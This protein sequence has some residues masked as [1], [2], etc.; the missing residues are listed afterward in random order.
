MFWAQGRL[1]ASKGLAAE[2][3]S[4]SQMSLTFQQS[5]KAKHGLERIRM[6]CAEVLLLPVE[7]APIEG[8]SLLESLLSMQQL[9]KVF[10]G[11]E[12][13]GTLRTQQLLLLIKSTAEKKFGVTSLT[14][15]PQHACQVPQTLSYTCMCRTLVALQLLQCPAVVQLGLFY[16]AL[17]LEM[18]GTRELVIGRINGRLAAMLDRIWEL[19]CVPASPLMAPKSIGLCRFATRP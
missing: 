5:R 19:E 17:L 3:L 6:L 7:Q 11:G 12:C 15:G 9:G 16:A 13:L 10:D 4:R 1:Q 14:K 18:P 2:G 8:L